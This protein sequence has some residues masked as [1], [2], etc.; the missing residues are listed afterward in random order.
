MAVDDVDVDVEFRNVLAACTGPPLISAHTIYV[1][2]TVSPDGQ[3]NVP[4][5]VPFDT[6]AFVELTELYGLQLASV[7]SVLYPK[8]TGMVVPVAAVLGPVTV[9]VVPGPPD[10]GV[11][12]SVEVVVLVPV[13]VKLPAS[14]GE[15]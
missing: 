2:P 15:L 11:L 6:V 10:V 8:L 13:T 1:V 4:E 7:V 3:E 14:T 9:T 12:T 5:K